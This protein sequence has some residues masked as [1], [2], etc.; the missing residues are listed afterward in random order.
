[1]PK[2][3]NTI[4]CHQNQLHFEHIFLILYAV[5]LLPGMEIS[6]AQSL[7]HLRTKGSNTSIML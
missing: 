1:M 6:V 5:Q 4:W 7:A 3:Q 2:I